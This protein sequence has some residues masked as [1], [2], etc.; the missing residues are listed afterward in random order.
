[1]KYVSFVIEEDDEIHYGVLEG[2]TIFEV[3]DPF[4]SSGERT[5]ASYEEKNV[6]YIAPC[7][8]TKALC[9]GMNYRD[10]AEEFGL[11][12]PEVPIIF[13][14]PASS[15]ADPEGEII[16]P[17]L[18]RHL[19]YEAELA[20]VISKDC[21]NVE[22][23]EALNYVFGYTC[24]N[25]VTARDLQP[26]QGQWTLAKG[27]DTFLPLGPW[28]ETDVDPSNLSIEC[29]VNGEV[30]QKSNTK[31][32]IFDVPYLV[33]YLS[34]VMTLQAGD[35]ILTG[36]PSGISKLMPGDVVEVEIGGIGVLRNTVVAEE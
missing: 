8:P 1:M 26:K 35:V 36:T 20:I 25:D 33:S 15:L 9:V 18:S 2:E 6:V 3:E 23:E 10:H 11:P 5:G 30:K 14:K 12:I 34:K 28:I 7:L 32:L 29:R 31:N 24:A 19:D 17:K 16:F 22:K 27:F 21:H 13:M 4:I